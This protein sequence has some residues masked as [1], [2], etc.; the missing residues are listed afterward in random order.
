MSDIVPWN[1]AWSGED[2]YGI[3]PCRWAGGE[4][5]VW[6][7]HSPGEGKPLF[8]KPHVVRQRRS[9]AELRCTVCGERTPPGDRWWFRLGAPQDGLFM[10]TEAP[11]H[12]ACALRALR[13]C[14]HLRGRE[15]A[16]APFPAGYRILS[17]IVGGPAMA[18]DFGLTIP[19]GRRVIGSLK[20]A[21]PLRHPSITRV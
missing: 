7:R 5:A 21:W 13:L 4:L 2:L 19:P 3:R 1:A 16:L 11:V 6:Q 10:T 15:D 20:L 8:A 14:P 18:A 12:H 9:I 17:A